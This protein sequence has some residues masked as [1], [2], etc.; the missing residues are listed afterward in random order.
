MTD[1]TL[2]RFPCPHCGKV[3]KTR[4]DWAGRSATCPAC[5]H[6]FTLPSLDQ[7]PVSARMAQQLS[8]LVATDESSPLDEEAA[9]DLALYLS[10]G[11]CR[12]Y[13]LAHK[14]LDRRTLP[15]RTWRRVLSSAAA[16]EN[17]RLK[18][19]AAVLAGEN[20]GDADAGEEATPIPLLA[21]AE[22]TAPN[23]WTVLARYLYFLKH[24]TC[25]PCQ[26]DPTGMGCIY[27]S[28]DDFLVARRITSER[29]AG[30]RAAI[31]QS[32]GV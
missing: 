13:D 2:Q 30:W 20:G 21:A 1:S 3:L 4:A 8:E 6:T 18:V 23:A 11:T 29:A 24:A 7:T 28:F 19:E 26:A 32:V 16:Q 22:N 15:A 31:R 12:D 27:L 14:L 10:Q 17:L 9:E 25:E 5:Q